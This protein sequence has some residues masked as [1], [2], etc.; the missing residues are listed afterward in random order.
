METKFTRTTDTEHTITLDSFILYAMWRSATAPAGGVA[1]FEVGTALVGVGAQVSINVKTK[2]G[3]DLGN[4]DFLMNF[5]KLVGESAIPE[6]LELG[7]QVYF[8]ANLPQHGLSAESNRIIVVPAVNVTNLQ[9]S[10]DKVRRD[11][12]VTLKAD[13]QNAF[14][15]EA[16]KI[17]I[18]LYDDAAVH[19]LL[20]EITTTVKN[21]AIE[22]QWQHD[23]Q[24][25]TVGILTE[26]E[27]EPEEL[28]Y[29]PVRYFFTVTVAGREFGK[30]QESGLLAFRDWL[31]IKLLNCTEKNRYKLKLPD[32][33]TREG[34]FDEHGV[35]REDD[36]PP[37]KYSVEISDDGA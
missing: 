14:E 25:D 7:E 29:N 10:T 6:D 17:K 35:L 33:T 2:S 19:Q 32:G 30:Q 9:W 1:I 16:A 34:R 37:G 11:E 22:L 4:V 5:N 23:Y 12:T 18:F 20:S 28:H 21:R 24:S 3:R 31:E 15:D 8:V 27:L 13:V 26:D 36:V